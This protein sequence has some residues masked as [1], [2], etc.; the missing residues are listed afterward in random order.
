MKKP[1]GRQLIYLGL[2]V[3]FGIGAILGSVMCHVI[4]SMN[5]YGG[6]YY[7]V[8]WPLQLAKVGPIPNW[9]FTFEFSGPQG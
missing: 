9:A 1:T 4:P 5:F 2:A 7:A 6:V 8:T 3:Y